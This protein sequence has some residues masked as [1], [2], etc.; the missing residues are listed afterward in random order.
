MIVKC[1][2][3]KFLRKPFNSN[4]WK[5]KTSQRKYYIDDI[6]DNPYYLGLDKENVYEI[7]GAN[8]SYNIYMFNRWSYF[9]KKKKNKK[10]YL[11]FYFDSDYVVNIRYEYYL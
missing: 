11:A 5:N 3:R 4:R 2:I 10:F 1:F 8:E 6:L 7:F 9:V